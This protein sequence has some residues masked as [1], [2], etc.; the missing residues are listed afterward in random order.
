MYKRLNNGILYLFYFLFILTLFFALTSPNLILGDNRI[1]GAGT[2]YF[3]TI[4]LL[5]IG[6]MGV[7]L[8]VFTT[9]RKWLKKIFIDKGL[10]TSIISL[11]LVVLWQL[12]FVFLVHPAIGFDVSAIHQALVDQSNTTIRSYFSQNYNNLPL[13]LVQHQLAL[14]FK[15]TSWLFFDLITLFLVDLAAIFNIFTIWIIDRKKILIAIYLQVFWLAVFPMI[16][17]PYTDTWVLPLVAGYL[18]GYCM[19]F[20]SKRSVLFKMTGAILFGVALVAAYFLK[21]SAIIGGIAILLIELLQLFG[22]GKD[23]R[24]S[25]NENL[26]LVLLMFLSLGGS[27]Y[28]VSRTIKGQ[29]YIKVDQSREIPAIHF[30]SMGVSGNGGYNLKDALEMAKIQT[31]Q[32]RID[33]SKEVL[34]ERL[35]K[36]GFGGYLWFLV[37]KQ[38][39][40]TAD[41]TFAWVKE[42]NFIAGETKPLSDGV[43]RQLEQFIYL[44]GTRL[45]DFRFIAQIWWCCLLLLIA[46][47]WQERS[48]FVQML[49]LAIIGS[50]VYLLIFEGGRSRYLI[51]FLPYF[52]TLA[53]MVG[54]TTWKNWKLTYQWLSG[55]LTN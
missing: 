13:L 55:K 33:Y 47:G 43:A 38:Q 7:C 53:A 37:Q 34:W 12:L 26:L 40:N 8:I 46:W 32:G 20:H 27:Y 10:L 19:L 42:G 16:I 2:T 3:T 11:V 44:Y 36:K 29:Q 50:F 51:Q 14:V 5:I 52:L 39:S 23:T 15:T 41:G 48:R 4:V 54:S 21:P 1:T 30:I 9:F 24:N 25:R 28:Y 22:I 6:T 49:R 18:L 31:K 17:V 35:Q 45:G